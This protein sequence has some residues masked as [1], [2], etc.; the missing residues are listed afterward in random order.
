MLFTASYVFTLD[1]PASTTQ[2]LTLVHSSAQL[3][4][5]LVAEATASIHFSAQP[6]TLLPVEPLN[7]A[8]KKCSRQA[9]K[10]P[11]VAPKKRLH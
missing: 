11:R 8:N 6:E 9:E 1:F 5:P 10:L 4:P 2:G 3:E 7:I